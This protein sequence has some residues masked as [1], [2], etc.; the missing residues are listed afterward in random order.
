ML[1]GLVRPGIG[2]RCRTTTAFHN[3]RVGNIGWVATAKACTSA[4][5]RGPDNTVVPTQRCS[6]H[7]AVRVG[8]GTAHTF[9]GAMQL[10]SDERPT[11]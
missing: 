10:G 5:G 4:R 6:Y 9:L 8:T 7:Q 3:L 11:V 2:A 1:D